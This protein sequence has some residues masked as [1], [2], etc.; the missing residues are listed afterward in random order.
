MRLC[1]LFSGVLLIWLYFPIG[2][3]AIGVNWGTMAIRP[4]PP[5]IVAQMLQDN[6]IG[7]VKL[8][9][10]D[11]NTLKALVGSDIDVMVAIPNNMLAI[12]NDYDA[13]QHWVEKNV[14]RYMFDGGVNIKY[15][16]VGNEPFLAAYN[17]SFINT[18]F[19]ALQN[20]QNALNEAGYGDKI[21]ATVPLNAD[22]Y[23]SPSSNPVPSTGRFRSDISDIMTQIVHFFKQ[24]N[25]SFT[26][27]IYP[28][29]SLYANKDFP[30]DYAFFEGT[31][32]P[33]VDNGIQYTNVFDAN[34]DTLVSALKAA[35]VPDLPIIVGEVGWPTDGDIN[36]NNNY[37]QRFY[38]G[39]LPRLARKQGT[40]LR[41]NVDID[42][43]LFGLID[44]DAK[45]IDPGN[46]ER[47]WGI[48]HYDGQPKFAM[49][50]SGQQPPTK[51][52]IAAKNVKYLPQKWCVLNPE[53]SNL[54]KLHL[55]LLFSS[56]PFSEAMR[57]CGSEAMRLCGWI[58]L[59]W[60]YFPIGEGAVGVNWG[61][62]AIRPLPPKIV[63][64]MLQDNGIGKVKLFDADENTL[65]ALVG[66]DI[67]VMVAIPNNMLAIMNDYDAA[68][69]W[70]DKNVSRYMFDGGVNIKYVAVGNEPF[71][72]AYNGSF[73]NTTFPALQNIQNALN[74]AGYGDKIKATVPLN[75][76]VYNSPSSNPVPSTGRFRSDISDIMTQI[77]HF[78]KQNNASFTVNIYPFLS[79]YA[80]KDFPFDYAFFEG[81]GKPIVDNGIQYTNVFDANFDTLVSA[82]KAAGVP[83]LP[84]I[85]GE[86]G[87]PTDGD[88]NANNN[89]AQRFYNGLLPRLAHK[90][91]SPLRPNVDIDVYLFGLIDEDAKSIDP[92]NFERHWGIF[93]YDGQ[94]KFAMDL[95]GQQPP[96]KLL[97][98]A[99]NVKY[100]QQKWCVLNPEVSDLDKLAGNI[101]FA[102][103]FSDCTA[104]G[105]G[106]SC[107][108]L[109]TNGNAS[110]AFNMY[111]QA[112]GQNELGCGFQG[113]G[114]VT[115]QNQSTDKCNFIIQIDSPASCRAFSLPL[116]LIFM[117]ISLYVLMF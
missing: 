2:E 29:L 48:F 52:L 42:V 57:L 60:L 105:Y 18:T 76:D 53:V 20:I 21:K 99:K 77:V 7:K 9:D 6:G 64:Q 25:A 63:A 72:A 50:L 111:F 15:V 19:P 109:D 84:I 73:I 79:L 83:D 66:S 101:N 106:S 45:S 47:H 107:N 115:T 11:E 44:E 40:P 103:T 87:W 69:R 26:V 46:F 117:L 92:G 100:L 54:D 61:T 58:L 116:L 51:L 71:L 13:A 34:F 28:F 90:Q 78:F 4:L 97:V 94:P 75:A 12:M 110:Y 31:G 55:P 65:K 74:E 24:N 22:V 39:L 104:L 89:Y 98:A 113:L 16:A 108:G 8:F 27:N 70:V 91:G 5:K 3:G 10:A 112:Q 80:N 85:V 82:L 41:P 37:A 68:Q 81:T 35:G 14:S 43:Y 23:N 17:G 62:M 49:D 96:T 38:N 88:I 102:C 93:H 36:A 32:K 1:G 56:P 30:F 114:M 59:T 86:V 33:I 95:S 67:E